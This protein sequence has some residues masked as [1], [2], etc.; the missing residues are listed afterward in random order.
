MPTR[1]LKSNL[2]KR[3]QSLPYYNGKDTS[4]KLKATDLSNILFLLLLASPFK[5]QAI[6]VIKVIEQ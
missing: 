4:L 5:I 2:S 6:K 1:G 3:I